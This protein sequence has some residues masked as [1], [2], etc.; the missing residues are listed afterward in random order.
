VSVLLVHKDILF[1]ETIE[2]SLESWPVD[3]LHAHS[4]ED[5]IRILGSHDE[6]E[7]V[8]LEVGAAGKQAMDTLRV[9]KG[10]YPLVEVLMLTEPS[11]ME[12]AVE[13][14]LLGAAD[15]LMKDDDAA[16][17]TRKIREAVEKKR[18]HEE[19]IIDARTCEMANRSN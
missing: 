2:K 5:A 6:I 17:L 7:V 11:S 14:M 19:K 1:M 18:R 10:E 15:Y 12:W 16:E 8:I 3:L 9:I 4:G 13:G